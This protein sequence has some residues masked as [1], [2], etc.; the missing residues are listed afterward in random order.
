[1]LPELRRAIIKFV[2]DYF[3]WN[4]KTQEKYR[5]R[6]P[7]EVTFNI[8]QFLMAELF[9]IAVKNEEK[10][11]ETENHFTE[12]QWSTINGAMLP[13]QGI[14]ENYFFLN[15]SFARD[16]SIL[17]FP[18]LYD[19]DFA[20]YQ[21]QEEWRKKDVANYQGKPY[22]GSLYSTWARLQIDGSFSYAILSMQAAY[23]Y[24]EVDEFGHDYI[25]ELIPYEFKPGKDH[26]KKEGNGYVFDMTEDA[27]GLEPQLKELKQRFW[28]HLQEIYEQFQIEFSKA[29]RRQV[30]IID[31][32]RKDEPEHQ[33]IFSDK[34]ILSCISFKTFLVDCR[35]YKQRD[36]SIL[37][38]RIEKEKKLMQQFLNDQYADITA[39]FNGKVIKL[40]KKRRIIIHKDSGLEGLL[41]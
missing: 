37:V 19:Y 18:T 1:M 21:F 38:D 32:S 11:D 15:E 23:I 13:L 2:P 30:F 25:E 24:S 14:G 26:G 5:V 29:S 7:Q 8:R 34:E 20:D 33:F 27:N 35:K 6:M 16:Q 9:G 36:F 31:T 12:A 17:S 3:S 41:D 22:H 40:T 4:E 10:M 28:K 39:D